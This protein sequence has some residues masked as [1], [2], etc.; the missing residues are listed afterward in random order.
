[1]EHGTCF[2]YHPNAAKAHLVVK[3]EHAEKVKQQFEGT[4]INIATEGK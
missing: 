4:D 1:M 2:G 3:A